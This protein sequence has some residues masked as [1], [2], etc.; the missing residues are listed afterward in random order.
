MILIM[1]IHRTNHT[2]PPD[3]H[4]HRIQTYLEHTK[5]FKVVRDGANTV[6]EAKCFDYT[7]TVTLSEP[8]SEQLRKCLGT[9]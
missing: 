7:W 8:E 9:G 3:N 1:E 5:D 4:T 6:I 2:R